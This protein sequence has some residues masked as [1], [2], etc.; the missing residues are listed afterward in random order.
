MSIWSGKESHHEKPW[1]YEKRWMSPFGMGGKRIHLNKGCRNSLKY[2]KSKNQLLICYSGKVRI[3]APKEKEF[4]ETCCDGSYFDLTPG[5]YILI[6]AENP[7]RV[8]A[9][10]ESDLIE[11]VIGQGESLYQGLVMLEDDYGRLD[12]VNKNLD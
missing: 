3:H 7:Y 12:N 1:G 8:E 5:E 10:L 9:L 4:G 2:Y 11:V 6:Q